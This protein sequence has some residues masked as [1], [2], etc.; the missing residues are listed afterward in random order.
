[1]ANLTITCDEASIFVDYGTQAQ[2]V[3]VKKGCYDKSSVVSIEMAWDESYVFVK[4][5][6]YGNLSLTYNPANTNPNLLIVDSVHGIAPTSQQDLFNMLVECKLS[7]TEIITVFSTDIDLGAP[8]VY[9]FNGTT[10]TADVPDISGNE[11]KQYKI[12]NTGSGDLTL[13]AGSAVLFESGLP[14]STFIIPSGASY[15]II[16]DGTY[17]VIT[18]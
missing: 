9:I 4:K 18:N 3:A 15:T 14:V 6:D 17:W 2:L 1:M 10:A 12:K 13:D 11:G 16:D 8:G 7:E 5:L